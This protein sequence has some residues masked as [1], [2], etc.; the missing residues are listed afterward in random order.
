MCGRQEILLLSED[1]LH[2]GHLPGCC[3]VGIQ[4][5]THNRRLCGEKGR[6]EGRRM[7]GIRTQKKRVRTIGCWVLAIG[8]SLL[9]VLLSVKGSALAQPTLKEVVEGKEAPAQEQK[10]EPKKE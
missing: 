6:K 5:L 10:A 2:E 3:T 7:M 1:R 4:L 8:V 9:W